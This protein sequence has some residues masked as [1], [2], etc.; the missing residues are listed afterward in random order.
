MTPDALHVLLGVSG[1]PLRLSRRTSRPQRH[2]PS[3]AT[4]ASARGRYGS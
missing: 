3:A 4:M 1:A 2:D